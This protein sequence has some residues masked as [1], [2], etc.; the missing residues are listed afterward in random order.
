MEDGVNVM[1]TAAKII[2]E[3][4]SAHLAAVNASASDRNLILSCEQAA[5]KI[6]EC[7]RRGGKLIIC[8][9]GGSAADA[10]HLAAEFIN[11]YTND[12][13]PLPAISLAANPSNIT[14]IGN[15]YSFD[16]VFSKQVEALGREGDIL[17][18]IST[19]GSSKNIIEAI[20]AAKRKSVYSILFTGSRKTPACEIADLVVAVPSAE[21][22]RIQEMHI[23]LFHCICGIVES[24]LFGK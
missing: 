3:N 9:N 16:M 2:K 1:G 14:S 19:S 7:F 21:T 6:I 22:P 12:R 8:G 17:I 24:E 13:A 5:E 18:A 11:R 20:R 23:L 10:N 15:D 4:F